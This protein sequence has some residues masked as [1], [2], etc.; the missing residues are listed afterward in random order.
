[1]SCSHALDKIILDCAKTFLVYH[2]RGAA[3]WHHSSPTTLPFVRLRLLSSYWSYVH[4]LN[5]ILG[6]SHCTILQRLPREQSF[7]SCQDS[8]HRLSLLVRGAGWRWSCFFYTISSS[9]WN[10]TPY[11]WINKWGH[12]YIERIENWFEV[13]GGLM[14]IGIGMVPED[15]ILPSQ[16]LEPPIHIQTIPCIPSGKLT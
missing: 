8:Q 14:F 1:M 9:K 12:V 6:A 5:A 10:D 11:K 16:P 2:L 15:L 7:C 4:Q 13:F 3:F